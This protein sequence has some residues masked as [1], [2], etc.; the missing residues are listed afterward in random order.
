MHMIDRFKADF[1]LSHLAESGNHVLL[2]AI[3]N[4]SLHL[5]VFDGMYFEQ[6]YL[7]RF[8]I[9]RHLALQQQGVKS[10]TDPLSNGISLKLSNGTYTVGVNSN[11]YHFAANDSAVPKRLTADAKFYAS[12]ERNQT[13]SN[14]TLVAKYSSIDKEDFVDT[15]NDL[16]REALLFEFDVMAKSRRKYTVDGVHSVGL[17]KVTPYDLAYE[18]SSTIDWIVKTTHCDCG[19]PNCAFEQMDR[20]LKK[21]FGDREAFKTDGQF[22]EI[23]ASQEFHSVWSGLNP[24]AQC[25][26]MYPC[27]SLGVTPLLFIDLTDSPSRLNKICDILTECYQPDSEEEAEVRQVLGYA[28]AYAFMSRE[29]L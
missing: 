17:F 24:E 15:L 23:K 7:P 9:A 29:A 2:G 14:M 13:A 4:L 16:D 5:L 21:Y 12:Q 27:K 11:Q 10:S 8:E 22:D 19:N 3:K 26:L 6:Y 1:G 28:N 25:V 18:Y 20:N